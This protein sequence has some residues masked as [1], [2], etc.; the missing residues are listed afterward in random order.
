M[1]KELINVQPI[2]D[3]ILS[4]LHGKF[5]KTKVLRGNNRNEGHVLILLYTH[6]KF[7]INVDI[8]IE[9]LLENEHY[10]DDFFENIF[11][12]LEFSQ[13]ARYEACRLTGY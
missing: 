9:K 5:V 2:I 3:G 6:D 1:G 10:M 13:K 7:C 8:D 4:K 11:N 12:S